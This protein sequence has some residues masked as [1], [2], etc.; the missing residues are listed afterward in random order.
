MTDDM[1]RALLG[2]QEAAKR[3]TD[4]GALLQ[5]V[6]L[7]F[8]SNI[9]SILLRTNKEDVKMVLPVRIKEEVQP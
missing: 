7:E 8:R 5:P 6:I 2:D 3:L 4:V 9:E 1:K